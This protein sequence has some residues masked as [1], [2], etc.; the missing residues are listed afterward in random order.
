MTSTTEPTATAPARAPVRPWMIVTAAVIAVLVLAAVG[1]LSDGEGFDEPT[2][3]LSLGTEAA[4]A[5]CP[6]FDPATLAGMAPAFAGTA[7][8]VEDETV[9][10]VVDRWYAGDEAAIV[11][12][13]APAGLEAL[14]GGIRFEVGQQYLI[15]ATDG[16]V[17][18]C[19]Y[20]GPATPE[21]QAAFDSAF[22]P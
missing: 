15:T 7:R 4:S 17:N 16:T 1:W 13:R 8:T 10:L 20:S 6:V 9:I 5:S 18:Y 21:L 11:E 2:L 12:L 19:G 22:R 3:S 14:T